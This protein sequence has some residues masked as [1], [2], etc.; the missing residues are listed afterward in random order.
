[1][2][3]PLTSTTGDPGGP[4]AADPAGRAGRIRSLLHEERDAWRRHYK[5]YFKHA[6]RALGLGFVGGFLYFLLWPAQEQ[7]ALELVI[8]ALKDIRLEGSALVLALT[9]FYHNAR[10]SVLAVAAGTVPFLFLPIL[11]PLVNG[12][13][14]GLLAS[15]S[16]HNG[17][18]VPRIILTQI[19]PHGVF[20]LTAV[21]YAT[22]LGLYLSAGLGKKAAAAWKTRKARRPAA[23]AP[24]SGAAP[25]APPEI[26]EGRL[27]RNVVR[28]FAL[29]VLPLLLVAAF[30]E[31][32]ITPH[33]R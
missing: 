24:G 8:D 2:S 9:L 16:K 25:A 23:I 27:T 6:A 1:M 29:V 10:A 15:V 17:L 14:L 21:C 12:A 13:V 33:L 28:S 18:D 26:P 19:L 4:P 22:S 32:F 30:V 20:E 7:K 5:K 3:E 11:D 31:G